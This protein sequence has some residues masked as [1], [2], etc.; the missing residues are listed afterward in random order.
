[1]HILHFY[2]QCQFTAVLLSSIPKNLYG[3]IYLINVPT[4]WISCRKWMDGLIN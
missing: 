3:M 4:V 1:M 2:M